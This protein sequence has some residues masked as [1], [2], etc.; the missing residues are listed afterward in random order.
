MLLYISTS[1][2]VPRHIYHIEL[3]EHSSTIFELEKELL[4][5]DPD[6]QNYN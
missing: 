1:L 6:N 5:V 4:H 2:R 3:K